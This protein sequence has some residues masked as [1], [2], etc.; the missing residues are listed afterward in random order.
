MF[1]YIALYDVG[2]S[3][4]MHA[5]VELGHGSDQVPVAVTF[6]F[7]VCFMLCTTIV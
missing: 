3:D 6:S 4:S 7:M 5:S 2:L 1:L